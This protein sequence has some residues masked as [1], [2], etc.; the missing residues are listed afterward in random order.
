MQ[1]P[2]DPA[3]DCALLTYQDA[4]R[5]LAVSDRTVWSLVKRGELPVVKIGA[6]VRIDPA[7]LLAYIAAQKT[8]LD[9]R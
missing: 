5:R 4:A 7:D 8:P 2:C 9:G 1:T 6:A 3:A